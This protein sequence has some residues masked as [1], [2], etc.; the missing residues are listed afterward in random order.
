MNYFKLA[1]AGIIILAIG[2]GIGY[3]MAPDKIKIEEKIVEKIK[4]IVEENKK[5]TEKFD[6]ATGKVVERIQETGTKQTN[7]NTTKNEKTTEK[8][9][10]RKM[11]AVKAGVAKQLNSTDGYIPRLGGEVRLPFF[12]S[13]LGVEADLVLD[14]PTLGGYLRV[15]F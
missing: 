8:E 14:R 9:K 1:L 11:W 7:V 3:F 10:T 13:W 15:E 12:N 4:T 6:P 2:T 5:V